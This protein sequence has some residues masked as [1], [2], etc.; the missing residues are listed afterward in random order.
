MVQGQVWGVGA[1]EAKLEN[2]GG[3][4]RKL[5]LLR[6]PGATWP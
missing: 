4:L 1:E 2:P 6:S 5:P 3:Q